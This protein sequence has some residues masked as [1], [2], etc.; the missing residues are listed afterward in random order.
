LLHITG[1]AGAI[2]KEV[3]IIK[4]RYRYGKD[5]LH[6]VVRRARPAPRPDRI[7]SSA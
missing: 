5:D 7:G 6:L 3:K 2:D 1:K 4:A